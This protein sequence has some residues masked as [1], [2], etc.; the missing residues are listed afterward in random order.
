MKSEWGGVNLG[1][2]VHSQL[3]HFKDLIGARVFVEGPPAQLTPAAAQ[4][5]GMALHELATNA[6]KYGALSNAEGKVRIDWVL[7]QCGEERYFRMRWSEEGG[8]PA[9]KPKKRG[10]G[11]TVLVR[12]AGRALGAKVILDFPPSG[13]VWV[14]SAAAGNVIEA[15]RPLQ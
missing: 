3:G 15:D 5:I 9:V 10:F 7:A 6:A 8:P 2:L 4:S 12:L 11:Q 13:L 1:D 14:L